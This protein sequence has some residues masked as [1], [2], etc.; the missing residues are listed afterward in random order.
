[1]LVGPPVH[2]FSPGTCGSSARRRN[3]R[4]GPMP[5][6]EAAWTV[7]TSRWRTKT[8][9]PGRTGLKNWPFKRTQLQKNWWLFGDVWGDYIYILFLCILYIS[10]S[11]TKKIGI[12]INQPVEWNDRGFWRMFQ[13]CLSPLARWRWRLQEYMLDRMSGGITERK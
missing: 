4:N 7:A 3:L 9:C 6:V 8:P 11:L 10:L 5:A 1:M 13:W 2:V 12:L